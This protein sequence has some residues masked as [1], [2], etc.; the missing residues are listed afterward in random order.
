MSALLGLR[1]VQREDKRKKVSVHVLL[2]IFIVDI[3]FIPLCNPQ[4]L[5]IAVETAYFEAMKKGD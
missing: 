4:I 5:Q 3:K 2:L 1:Q